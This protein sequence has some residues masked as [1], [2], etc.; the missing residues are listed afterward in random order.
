MFGGA[1]HK[2]HGQV[3]PVWKNI[4]DSAGRWLVCVSF[5]RRG[6]ELIWKP[7]FDPNSKMEWG[8]RSPN[9]GLYGAA[10][11]AAHAWIRLAFLGQS[12]SSPVPAERRMD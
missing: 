8:A 12:G 1:D 11:Q 4:D 9:F 6:E 5:L 2:A 3:W 10:R 7:T